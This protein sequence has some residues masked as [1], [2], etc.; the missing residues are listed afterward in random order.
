MDLNITEEIQE[1]LSEIVSNISGIREIWLIG[2]RANGT[3]QDNSD[4]D[5]LVF[6]NSAALDKL[7]SMIEYNREYIDFL[8]VYNGDDFIEPW[9]ESPKSGSLK[10]WEWKR[11]SDYSAEYK[12]IKFIPDNDQKDSSL[13]EGTFLKKTV[14][15]IKVLPEYG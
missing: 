12:Q 14:N 1:Y 3:A 4:W 5:F 2:S 15:A 11:T 6:G 10:K 13:E 9:G 7:K 8:V